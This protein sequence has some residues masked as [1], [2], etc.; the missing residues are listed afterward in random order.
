MSRFNLSIAVFLMFISV[1]TVVATSSQAQERNPLNHIVVIYLEDHSFDNLYGSFPGANGL[2]QA[3]GAAVQIDKDGK[4]YATL[5]PPMVG[6]HLDTRFPADLPNKPFNI[7][8]YVPADQK[9]GD[10]V[11]RYYQEQMQ[12]DGGKM[13]KFVLD[14]DAA[15]L[16]MGYYDTAKLPL[17][18][19]ARQF[20]LADNFFHAAFGGSVLN[21]FWLI[22]AC[23]PSWGNAPDDQIATLDANGNMLKDGA[24]TPDGFIVNTS[25]SVYSPHPVYVDAFHLAPPQTQPTIGDRLSDK[26]LTWA[27]YSGG[28]DDT[29]SGNPNPLFQYQHQPF[30]YFKNYGNGKDGRKLHLKDEKDFIAAVADGSLPAVSF[31][32][33]LGPDTEHNGWAD[34]LTGEKHVASL[35]NQIQKSK[36]WSDTAIIITYDENG[37]FWDHVPPPKVDKWGPGSRVPTLIIS[38]FAKKGFV[39]HTQMDTTSILAFIE[40]RYGLQPLADRDKAANDM[41]SAFDFTQKP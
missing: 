8:K 9:I 21:H 16:V 14:S 24:V 26:N 38:P 2:D 25:F 15:G 35:I 13:D 34:L 3:G 33:P 39:D 37:G 20:T 18:E 22:C 7:N 27:W 1:L 11:H 10:P 41:M 6:D 23:S 4:P 19:Y 36:I 40:H 28:W 17:A 5:P 30:A 32:K 31:V 12:I 29:M